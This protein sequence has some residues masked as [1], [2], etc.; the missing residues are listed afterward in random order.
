LCEFYQESN[1]STFLKIYLETGGCLILKEIRQLRTEQK[2]IH[3][4]L[5]LFSGTEATA[6]KNSIKCLNYSHFLPNST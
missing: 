2:V 1:K 6:H 5:T 3:K 4:Q